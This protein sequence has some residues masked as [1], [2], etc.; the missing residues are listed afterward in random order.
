MATL[1]AEA[2]TQ[3]CKLHKQET[4]LT[5]TQA[6]LERVTRR[7]ME[8]EQHAVDLEKQLE[9]LQNS[10]QLEQYRAVT[11]EA[12]KWKV[13]EERWVKRVRE[14]EEALATAGTWGEKP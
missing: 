3:A 5:D 9:R 6:A 14:L 12:C 10:A 2:E 4:E 13:R 11:K 8:V 7:V 1:T